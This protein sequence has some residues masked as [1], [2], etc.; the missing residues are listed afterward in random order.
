VRSSLTLD[1]TIDIAF[2]ELNF[3]WEAVRTW[4]NNT[5]L[6]F[7]EWIF[8]Q[9]GSAA[10]GSYTAEVAVMGATRFIITADPENIKAAFATQFGE[11]GQGKML[12]D[13]FKRF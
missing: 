4:K 3:F 12:Y 1:D 7:W 5:S 11:W 6:E 8:E 9:N 13:T 10:R 2:K